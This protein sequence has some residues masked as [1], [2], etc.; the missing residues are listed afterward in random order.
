MPAS[1]PRSDGSGPYDGRDLD[2]LLSGENVFVPEGLR[3]VARTLDALRAAPARAELADEAAARAAF[4]RVMLSNQ[5]GSVWPAGSAS[6]ANGARTLIL[7]TQ[8]AGAEPRSAAHPQRHRHRRPPRRGRWQAKALVAAAV[9]VFG[10]ATAF[11]STLLSSGGQPGQAGQSPSAASSSSKPSVPG[12]RVEGTGRREPA[13]KPTPTATSQSGTST[14]PDPAKLCTQ[15]FSFV[16]HPGSASSQ[17]T[18]NELYQQLSEPAHGQRNVNN[19]CMHLLHWW[20]ATQRK[21][22]NFPGMPGPGSSPFNGSQGGNSPPG[23]GGFGNNG[24]GNGN[25]GNQGGP[26]KNNP[27]IGGQNH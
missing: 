10:G 14:T 13:A 8:A 17:A 6:G 3:P 23:H 26:G 22:D 9:V 27:G 24:T 11:A 18:E 12:S 20:A 15:Y 25:A 21:P 16:E 1:Q 19:Y 4:R 2:G 7:P 5:T